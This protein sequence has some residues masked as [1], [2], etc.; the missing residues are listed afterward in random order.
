LASQ[1]RTYAALRGDRRAIGHGAVEAETVAD[2]DEAGGYRP[3]EVDDHLADEGVEQV[4][5][6]L[7]GLGG[8]GHGGTSGRWT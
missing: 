4:R 2:E 5:V 8:R 3:A 6:G 1:G 7:A